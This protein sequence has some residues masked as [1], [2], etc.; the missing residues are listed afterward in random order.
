[1]FKFDFNIFSRH[2]LCDKCRKIIA[3]DFNFLSNEFGWIRIPSPHKKH[4]RG[5][6]RMLDFCNEK[7]LLVFFKGRKYWSNK[8]KLRKE[9]ESKS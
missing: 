5:K 1:M 6:G 8:M 4:K 2:V 9:N 7:C 3:T